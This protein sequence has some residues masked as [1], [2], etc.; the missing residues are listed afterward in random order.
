M[1]AGN[2]CYHLQRVRPKKLHEKLLLIRDTDILK[3][4]THFQKICKSK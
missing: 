4:V 3:V 2:G 1:I